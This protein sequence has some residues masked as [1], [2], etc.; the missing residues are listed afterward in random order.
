MAANKVHLVS[1]S[2]LSASTR[3][4]PSAPPQALE[5]DQTVVLFDGGDN[6]GILISGR[7]VRPIPA[8]DP[9]LRR[10]L[11]SVSM[12]LEAIGLTRDQASARKLS[13]QAVGLC[14]L[15]I[16]QVEEV[17][18]PLNPDRAI[19]YQSG[20]GGFACGALGKPPLA[21][22]WPP[23]ARPSVADLISTGAIGA[24]FVELLRR[25][26]DQKID[27]LEVFERPKDVARSLGVVLSE[28]TATDL[29]V[30]AASRLHEIGDDVD[31]EICGLLHVVARHGGLWESW[32]E[33]PNEVA[34][35]LGIKLSDEAIERISNRG[36]TLT[37]G[38]T[39][40]IPLWAVVPIAVVGVA[41]VAYAHYAE[42]KAAPIVM[43]RSGREKI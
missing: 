23:S 37:Y 4:N 32:L 29:N 3:N 17:L 7:G 21:F 27:L 12:L 26:T 39:A 38:P 30:L 1:T 14:N 31:R 40:A 18:G 36:A 24:D 20:D 8:F 16:E 5:R 6:G 42:H 19:V 33:R 15:A 25:A 10:T 28:K 35:G 34:S 22:A 43:D 41:A 11:K 9:G 2:S 13:K